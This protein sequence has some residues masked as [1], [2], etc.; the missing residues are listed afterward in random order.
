M[1]LSAT[2][3]NLKRRLFLLNPIVASFAVLC[4][5]AFCGEGFKEKRYRKFVVLKH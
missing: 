4:L 5:L 1:R 3:F 2:L